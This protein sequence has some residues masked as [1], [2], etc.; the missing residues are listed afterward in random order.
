[1][2]RQR[3]FQKKRDLLGLFVVALLLIPHS[4]WG[5][6]VGAAPPD[7]ELSGVAGGTVRLSSFRGQPIVLKIATT[8]C[9]GCKAQV[10]E[11]AAASAAL[12]EYN[13]AVVE[14]YVDEPLEDV[15]ADLQ[16]RTTS[17][18][19]VVAID[20][21]QV[22]R[23]YSLLGI[24]RVVLIDRNFKVVRDRGLLSAVDLTARL[25]TLGKD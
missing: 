12:K 19:S 21:G 15:Q 5:L 1:M 4:G 8:W 14:V 6:E 13:V 18:P 11:L 2:M 20:D 25:E 23:K 22:A 24:P 10:K 9:P 16:Q 3:L 7:F 17:L